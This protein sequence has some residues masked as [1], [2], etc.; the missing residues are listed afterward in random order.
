MGR[1]RNQG[2]ARRAAKAKA[3]EEAGEIEYNNQAAD[4]SE[5]PLATQIQ[6]QFQIDEEKCKHGFDRSTDITQFMDEFYSSFREDLR[7]G[8]RSI[9]TCLIG[10]RKATM[11]KFA[12]VWKDLAKMEMAMSAFYA[13]ARKLFFLTLIMLLPVRLPLLPDIL[14]NTSQLS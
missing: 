1:K 7:C 14:S 3:K 8:D 11:D 13:W 6:Q 9:A 12:A 5:Q 2:K 4:S 10:A